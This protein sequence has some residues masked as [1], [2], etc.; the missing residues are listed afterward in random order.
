MMRTDTA[1]VRTGRMV[2]PPN[3]HGGRHCR[4]PNPHGAWRGPNRT[5]PRLYRTGR[6][7]LGIAQP[8]M[9][10]LAVLWELGRLPFKWH[11]MLAFR[12]L[13]AYHGGNVRTFSQRAHL[14]QLKGCPP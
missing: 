14:S 2:P 6:S 7:L 9:P 3:R 12:L 11:V 13:A 1:E 4:P 5:L 10:G 8:L